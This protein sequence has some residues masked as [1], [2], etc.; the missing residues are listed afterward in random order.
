MK[1]LALLAALAASCL[2]AV[3]IAAAAAP[4]AA[5]PTEPSP[6]VT[7]I[8]DEPTPISPLL[9]PKGGLGTFPTKLSGP[10]V[11]RPGDSTLDCGACILTCWGATARNGSGDWSGHAY[12]YHHVT[13]CGNGAQVIYGTASQ[14]YDQ[15]GWYNINSGY[16]P[17]WSGGCVGCGSLTVTGYILWTWSTPLVNVH[18]SGTSYLNTTLYAYGGISV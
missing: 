15:A 2:C 14:S 10:V 8:V 18:S 11:G 1:S 12:I 16:G 9:L 17:W 13:W 5:A 7:T 3:P 4:A 6:S